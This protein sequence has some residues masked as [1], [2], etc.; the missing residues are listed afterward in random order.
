MVPRSSYSISLPLQKPPA[1]IHRDIRAVDIATQQR[2]RLLSIVPRELG[3]GAAGRGTTEPRVDRRPRRC[4]IQHLPSARAKEINNM[5]IKWGIRASGGGGSRRCFRD[6]RQSLTHEDASEANPS[7]GVLI[8]YWI[9][10]I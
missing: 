7:G 4:P 10:S 2:P 3:S 6:Q 9:A 1:N 8:D 5:N